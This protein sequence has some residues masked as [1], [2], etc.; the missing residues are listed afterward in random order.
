MA[1]QPLLSPAPAS[2]CAATARSP[3]AA[4]RN[5]IRSGD[6]VL[7]H[8]QMRQRIDLHRRRHFVDRAR[9]G[10][11]V[12]PV[13]IHRAGAAYAL[14]AGAAEG[15]RRVDLVLDPDD[16]VE[17]HRP[18]IV[19]VDEIGVDAR[20]FAVVRDPSDRCG[21]RSGA[22]HRRASARPCL[23]SLANFSAAS[24]RPWRPLS[25]N[26][27]LRLDVLH[28]VRQR[29]G[30]HRPVIELH[31]AGLVVEPGQRVLHPVLVVALG[32]ILA[33]MRAARFLAGSA[34][35][36]SSPPPARS[37]CRIPASRPG[38]NSRSASGR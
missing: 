13:D 28:F 22:W 38:P 19:A 36:P 4:R 1:L 30:M 34:P 9:A 2:R 14:A 33:R 29:V 21:I 5:S 25:I 32:E 12:Q 6:Q 27:L 17:N 15:E 37:D 20:I 7:D 35:S 16:G 10:E 24:V 31:L 11:R 8:R 3:R 18:A 26:P 23:L